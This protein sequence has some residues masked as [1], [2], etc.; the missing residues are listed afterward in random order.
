[1]N[2]KTRN[3]VGIFTGVALMVISPAVGVLLYSRGM[4][5]AFSTL[6]HGTGPSKNDVSN[7]ALSSNISEVINACIVGFSGAIIGLIVFFVFL[8]LRRRAERTP[9]LS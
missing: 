6:S 8:I 1:M 7:A 9:H 5:H 4:N 3:T 2:S